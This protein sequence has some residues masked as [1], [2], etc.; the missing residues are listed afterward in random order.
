VI[1]NSCEWAVDNVCDELEFCD[2]GTDGTDCHGL[3]AGP[4]DCYY[5]NDFICNEPTDC[6]AGTDTNDCS[7]DSCNFALDDVCDEPV[8]CAYGTDTTDCSAANWCDSAYDAICDDGGG[9]DVGGG[10]CEAGTDRA[11]CLIA[12]NQDTCASAEDGICDEGY[13]CAFGTDATDCASIEPDDSC[14][15]AGNGFCEEATDICEPGTD[16]TDCRTLSAT[17]GCGYVTYVLDGLSLS[18]GGPGVTIRACRAATEEDILALF[19]C[20]QELVNATCDTL[21]D[22]TFPICDN[23]ID[24][25]SI[26]FD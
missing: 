13:V 4:N 1:D 26:A 24:N 15:T 25:G 6:P 18:C 2:A 9:G 16:Y 8:D 5:A 17:T 19:A 7:M 22:G 14:S 3:A 11:D 12:T 21:S 23:V 10:S 20:G